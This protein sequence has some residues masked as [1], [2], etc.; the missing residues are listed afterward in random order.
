MI[1]ALHVT[2]FNPFFLIAEHY[3]AIRTAFQH[4][5]HDG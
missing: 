3:E 1:Y 2:P 4:N 5:E